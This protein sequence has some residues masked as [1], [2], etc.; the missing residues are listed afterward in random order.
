MKLKLITAAL[1]V[2]SMVYA[3][4]QSFQPHEMEAVDLNAQ[5]VDSSYATVYPTFFANE[6]T[7]EGISKLGSTVRLEIFDSRGL[8]LRTFVFDNG[9]QRDGE[10]L[11]LSELLAKSFV[12]RVFE[13]QELLLK[14]R[15]FK[16]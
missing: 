2:G 7:I 16:K 1:L 13:D 3:G 5:Q 9:L 4:V 15:I 8:L 11:D 6:V 12:V 10:V 14:Q